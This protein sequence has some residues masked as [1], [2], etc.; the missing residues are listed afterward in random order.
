VSIPANG[1]SLAATISR[2]L[3][4][5]EAAATGGRKP[6]QVRLPA[7][8]LVSGSNPSERDEFVSGIPIFAQIANALADAGYLVVRYDERGMGQSGGRPES[9]TFEEFAADARAVF[10]YLSK[11]KDV[12]P[13]RVSVIG[14]GE[15]G[16]VA[17]ILAAREQRL[18]A[19]VLIAT[20]AISGTELVLEQQRQLFERG[21]SAGPQQE[22]AIEQQKKILDAVMTGKGWDA[23]TPDIRK[24]VDTPLYRSFL[25]FDPEQMINR[26]RQPIL[27][28]QPALDREVPAYHG[29]QIAQ[30]SR[31]RIR[32][33]GTDF[34]QLPG[35]NHLLARA[36]T[37]DVSEYGTLPERSVSPAAILELSAWLNR[38]LAAPPAK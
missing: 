33:R 1:F 35:I 30:L 9:S 12:D 25:M 24:R 16:W 13:K 28:I 27:V 23:L 21:G 19:V 3:A 15:G 18:A 7:V 32:A 29:D 26:T 6:A 34:V 4:P 2:P 20:P 22:A 14:Y 36:T 38:T 11:R 37:G 8:I 17:L 31:S 5:V 10:T